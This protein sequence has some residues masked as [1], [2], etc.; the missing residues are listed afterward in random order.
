MVKEVSNEELK[1]LHCTNRAARK[2]LQP[3]PQPQLANYLCSAV[4]VKVD[5][6]D[7]ELDVDF[8][9]HTAMAWAG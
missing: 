8:Q 7:E 4:A 6:S 9:K 2:H 3:R 5:F 1:S